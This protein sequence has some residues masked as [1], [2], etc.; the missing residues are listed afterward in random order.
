ML[1]LW[2]VHVPIDNKNTYMV[3]QVSATD[4]DAAIK[5]ALT[6]RGKIIKIYLSSQPGIRATVIK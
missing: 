3:L 4:E 2:E 6:K 1:K 5:M